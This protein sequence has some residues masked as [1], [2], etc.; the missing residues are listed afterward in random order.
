MLFPRSV[1]SWDNKN[2]GRSKSKLKLGR[3]N[4]KV[5]S[6]DPDSSRGPLRA[7]LFPP[8][9]PACKTR[10]ESSS[11]GC[12][13][14]LILSRRCI[15]LIDSTRESK[16]CPL[17]SSSVLGTLRL[18]NSWIRSGKNARRRSR[19]VFVGQD[20]HGEEEQK[21]ILRQ[22]LHPFFSE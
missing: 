11:D 6:R 14:H 8:P 20:R 12:E 2:E 15:G 18:G 7:F 5:G 3:S 9:I 19:G 10:S 16:A 22:S 17:R 13:A 1:S 4:S 21:L